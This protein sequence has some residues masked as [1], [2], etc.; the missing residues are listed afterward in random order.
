M[1][2]LPAVPAHAKTFSPVFCAAFPQTKLARTSTPTP[3]F[4]KRLFCSGDCEPYHCFSSWIFGLTNSDTDFLV[5]GL[6]SSIPSC[7]PCPSTQDNGENA[8]SSDPAAHRIAASGRLYFPS[9]SHTPASPI[10]PNPLFA[11][12]IVFSKAQPKNDCSSFGVSVGNSAI[13]CSS[14]RPESIIFFNSSS[15]G[16]FEDA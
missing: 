7:N 2:F 6:S 1:A 11:L 3:K 15:V 14:L 16:G 9:A 10:R 13:I 12:S 4:S 5:S 8:V